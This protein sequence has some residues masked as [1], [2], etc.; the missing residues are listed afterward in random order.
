MP[1]ETSPKHLKPSTTHARSTCPSTQITLLEGN[2]KPSFGKLCLKKN[3]LALYPG[4]GDYNPTA[5][6]ISTVYGS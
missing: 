4:Y 5:P 2:Y 1:T 6:V 3:I